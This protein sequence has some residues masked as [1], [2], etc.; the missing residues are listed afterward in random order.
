MQF[1]IN[2]RHAQIDVGVVGHQIGQLLIDLERLGIFF[3]GH[4][5]LTETALVAQ[6]RRIQLR[7]LA[8][9]RFGFGQI[10]RLRV[11]VAEQIEHA[12]AK[13]SAR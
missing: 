13:E 11:S 1:A 4:Q 7:G 10:M 3:F 6:F 8:I 5:G 9:S 12:R 2:L